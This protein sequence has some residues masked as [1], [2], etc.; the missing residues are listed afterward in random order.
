M[1]GV[2]IIVVP[3]CLWAL[4]VAYSWNKCDTALLLSFPHSHLVEYDSASGSSRGWRERIYKV[5]GDLETTVKE[6]NEKMPGF[7]REDEMASYRNFLDCEKESL[8]VRIYESE[9]KSD[10]VIIEV[11]T[12]WEE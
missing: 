1:F 6:M 2:F 8:S 3:I 12:V 11:M 7:V 4:P 10:E 9:E 5:E